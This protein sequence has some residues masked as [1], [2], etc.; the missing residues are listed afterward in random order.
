MQTAT[1]GAAPKYKRAILL[2]TQHIV[3]L[4]KPARMKKTKKKTAD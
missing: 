1:T 3:N 4:K 2:K